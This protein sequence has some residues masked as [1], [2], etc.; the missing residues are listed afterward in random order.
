MKT[1]SSDTETQQLKAFLITVQEKFPFAVF[2]QY[3]YFSLKP[4]SSEQNQSI[5]Y[6]SIHQLCT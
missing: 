4:I 6:L 3:A 5:H 1:Y 2:L